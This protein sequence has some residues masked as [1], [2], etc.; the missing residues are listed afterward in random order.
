M[1]ADGLPGV[2][3]VFTRDD[4]YVGI[5]IDDADTN[6]GIRFDAQAI[7]D[8]FSTYAERSPSGRGYHL[9]LKCPTPPEKG[10]KK[11]DIETYW[12][13]HY[14]TMTGHPL[15]R[16]NA[17]TD[18]TE[19][20]LAWHAEIFGQTMSTVAPHAGTAPRLAVPAS[21]LTPED[22]AIIAGCRRMSPEKFAALYNRGDLTEYDGDDSRAD[23][24][25]VGLV[26]KA[27]ATDPDSI[28]RIFRSSALM[29]PKWDDRAGDY[30]HRTTARALGTVVPGTQ[31]L[32]GEERLR[33]EVAQ[34]RQQLA[35]AREEKQRNGEMLYLLSRI[36]S[37]H[38][39]RNARLVA[40][41]L[42]V[43]FHSFESRGAERPY[44][45]SITEVIE[46]AGLSRSS[47]SRLIKTF[48]EHGIIRRDTTLI[49]GHVDKVTGEITRPKNMTHLSPVGSAVDF[50]RA[51]AELDLG[52]NWGGERPGAFGR[53]EGVEED[54]KRAG[55]ARDG[56]PQ[57]WLVSI[58]AAPPAPGMRYYRLPR[59]A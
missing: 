45:I 8:R 32:S 17:I 26:V 2:G 57:M 6:E 59:S 23:L 3:F 43:K 13:N 58:T 14:L 37:N 34:L 48:E 38:S 50:A 40:Y 28:D 18:Y 56:H 20:Y 9:I 24:A 52:S 46:A 30:R 55:P 51:A 7:L 39:L 22:R 11:D 25:L 21:G 42:A 4:P 47:G 53:P 29:R 44:P 49:P 31:T 12:E 16:F 19:G 27:G 54:P 33:R 15:S 36:V 35:T 10:N 1:H 5:D 41:A